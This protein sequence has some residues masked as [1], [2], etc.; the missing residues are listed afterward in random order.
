MVFKRKYFCSKL[1]NVVD[2][3][4][5]ISVCIELPGTHL[6]A[7]APIYLYIPEGIVADIC[8]YADTGNILCVDVLVNYEIIVGNKNIEPSFKV[9]SR[10]CINSR[11][12]L[13]RNYYLKYSYAHEKKLYLFL[14][15]VHVCLLR[16]A[17]NRPT[18]T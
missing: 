1:L 5:I 14:Y 12:K 7:P 11:R 16:A 18:I 6:R 8:L 15:Y 10:A 13:S 2:G 3:L 9:K 4:V 17:K